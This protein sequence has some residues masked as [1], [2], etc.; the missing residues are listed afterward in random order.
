MQAWGNKYFRVWQGYFR[1]MQLYLSGIADDVHTLVSD[2]FPPSP[3]FIQTTQW[4]HFW[5]TF[6]EK[7]FDTVLKDTLLEVQKEIDNQVNPLSDDNKEQFNAN[8]DKLKSDTAYGSALELKDGVQ[9]FYSRVAQGRH[10]NNTGFFR[11][12]CFGT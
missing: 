11:S 1:N 12:R 4:Y 5:D 9:T 8:I 7:S 2:Y 6:R 3:N 10:R